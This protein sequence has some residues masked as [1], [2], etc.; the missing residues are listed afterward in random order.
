MLLS[1]G[2]IRPLQSRL[3]GLHYLL[4]TSVHLVVGSFKFMGAFWVFY[5]DTEFEFYKK[6]AK[7]PVFLNYRS[8]IPNKTKRS[9]TAMRHDASMIDALNQLRE[10]NIRKPSGKFFP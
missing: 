1:G 8:A 2:E 10:R 3:D 5:G 4:E 7:K 6:K 9:I